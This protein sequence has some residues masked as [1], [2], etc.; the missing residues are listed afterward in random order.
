MTSGTWNQIAGHTL[1]AAGL[2]AQGRA[3]ARRAADAVARWWAAYMS[4]PVYYRMGAFD[5][6]RSALARQ[7]VERQRR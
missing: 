1:T 5:A 4:R 7:L 2:R 3:L 6:A